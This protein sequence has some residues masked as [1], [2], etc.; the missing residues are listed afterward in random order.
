MSRF[1]GFLVLALLFDL[2]A[3]AF[4]VAI[5]SEDQTDTIVWISLY[6][7]SFCAVLMAAL[8]IGTFMRKRS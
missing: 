8:F 3:I 2:S 4:S 1:Q 6:V 5:L 7:Q